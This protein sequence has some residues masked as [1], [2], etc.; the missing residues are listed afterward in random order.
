V[1]LLP[2]AE[3][4]ISRIGEGAAGGDRPQLGRQSQPFVL[5]EPEPSQTCIL[6]I[7]GQAEDAGNNRN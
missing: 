5:R 3:A 7:E 1:S 6:P 2:P 4:F